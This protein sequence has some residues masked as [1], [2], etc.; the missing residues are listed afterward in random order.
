MNVNIQ[1]IRFDADRKLED[2]I[3]EKLAKLERFHD[4]IHGAEVVLRLEHDGEKRE[5]KVVEVRLDVP[6]NDLFARR[7]GKSF[8]EAAAEAIDA[9][10]SQVER[11][12]ESPRQVS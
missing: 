12:R 7:Q 10:R 2:F 9:L 3:K 11:T 5:N 8:E 4:R 6:G 1:S